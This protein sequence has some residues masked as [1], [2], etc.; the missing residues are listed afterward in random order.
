V[1]AGFAGNE[2]PLDSPC[3]TMTALFRKAISGKLLRTET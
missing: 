2:S 1:F 3:A